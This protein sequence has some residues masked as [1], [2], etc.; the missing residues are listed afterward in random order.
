M[1]NPVVVFAGNHCVARPIAVAVRSLA[2]VEPQARIVVLADGWSTQDQ[3]LLKKAAHPTEVRII[4]A[5]SDGL[6]RGADGLPPVMYLRF[7][8]PDI[9]DGE[10]FA[11]YLDADTLIRR[12][13]T[14]LVA[15]SGFSDSG[16]STA[17]VQDSEIPFVGCVPGLNSLRDSGVDLRSPFINAGVLLMNLDIWRRDR[18]G[19]A[20]LSWKDEHPE[21]WGDNEALHGV[22]AGQLHLLPIQWNATTHMMRPESAVFGFFDEREVNLARR[23]PN[24]VHFTGAVKPWHSNASSPFLHEWR[25]VA[26]DIGW[27]TFRHSFSLRRRIERWVISRIDS[28]S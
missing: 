13:I 17:G 20:V 19:L 14:P 1:T 8:I 23:D 22:L 6:P 24:L 26:A 4:E 21:S 18:I 27:T 15:S 10:A 28:Q 11:V 7:K 16:Y 3:R 9:L 12:P 25:S 5:S 2:S